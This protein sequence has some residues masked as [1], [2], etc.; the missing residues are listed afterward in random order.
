MRDHG[1]EVLGDETAKTLAVTE[2]VAL[3]LCCG[4]RE[5]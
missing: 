2:G 4:R 1:I 3:R 5:Q